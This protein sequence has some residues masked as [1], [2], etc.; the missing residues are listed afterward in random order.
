VQG[1]NDMSSRWVPLVTYNTGSPV[2]T[3]TKQHVEHELTVPGRASRLP[4]T[5][6]RLEIHRPA[7]RWGVSVWRFNAWGACAPSA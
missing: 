7:T 6:L 2:E 5:K 1:W 4:I 3:K